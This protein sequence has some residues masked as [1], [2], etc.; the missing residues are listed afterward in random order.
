MTNIKR[1]VFLPR[2]DVIVFTCIVLLRMK[3]D[4]HEGILVAARD[5][6][7]ASV[8]SVRVLFH[9]QTTACINVL[10]HR[11]GFQ[12]YLSCYFRSFERKNRN[13]LSGAVLSSCRSA[14]ANFRHL[15]LFRGIDLIAQ[16]DRYNEYSTPK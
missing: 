13:A 1:P 5:R 8:F 14:Y 12:F 11:R 6:N 10:K 16:P 15:R 2:T 7:L 9:V 4:T 3:L